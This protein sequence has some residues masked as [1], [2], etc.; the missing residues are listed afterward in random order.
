MCTPTVPRINAIVAHTCA[1]GWAHTDCSHGRHGSLCQNNE[2]A[3]NN[4]GMGSL[5]WIATPKGPNTA[6]PSQSAFLR[7]RFPSLR[8][9]P[10]NHEKSYESTRSIVRYIRS[11]EARYQRHYALSCTNQAQATDLDTSRACAYHDDG[12]QQ[13]HGKRKKGRGELCFG[14]LS[15]SGRGTY[16]N[17]QR[18][19]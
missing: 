11:P 1:A 12:H 13:R 19:L 2:T 6:A 3:R 7:A 15:A 10:P 14:G 18:T 5:R 8:P 4:L 9:H 16:Q 17:H